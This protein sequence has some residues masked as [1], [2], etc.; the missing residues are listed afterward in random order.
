MYQCSGN[1]FSIETKS[2][3]FASENVKINSADTEAKLKLYFKHQFVFKQQKT[4]LHKTKLVIIFCNIWAVKCT[5]YVSTVVYRDVNVFY[6][7]CE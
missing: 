5:F 3:F 7:E 6:H 4:L 2:I 1:I